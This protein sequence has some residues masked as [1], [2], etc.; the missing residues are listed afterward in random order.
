VSGEVERRHLYKERQRRPADTANLAQTDRWCCFLWF[1]LPRVP[2]MTWV[3]SSPWRMGGGGLAN[4]NTHT[5]QL[6]TTTNTQKH[7]HKYMK[8]SPAHLHYRTASTATHRYNSNTCSEQMNNTFINKWP[9][10]QTRRQ[11]GQCP[12]MR[13]IICA[14]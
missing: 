5:Q 12:H 2:S 11:E 4:V 8:L 14:C 13:K 6:Y 9:V 3:L 1:L 10:N 7:K